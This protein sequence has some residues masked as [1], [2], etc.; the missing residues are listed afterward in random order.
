MTTQ[1]NEQPNLPNKRELIKSY[2]L[3][4]KQRRSFAEKAADVLTENFGT[5]TFLVINVVLF[6]LWILANTGHIPSVEVFDPYPFNFLTMVVSL[7]A[8]ILSIIV[9]MSQ[10]REAK[11]SDVRSEVDTHVDIVAE[12]EIT[13][14]LELMVRLLK[15]NGI[16]VS[17]DEA[18]AKML[19]PVDKYY[20]EKKFE[21]EM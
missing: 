8:I 19:K 18:L 10:N 20:L 6:F 14:L 12:E 17:E 5:F 15:K 2:K 1:E 7:E 9:L 3:K 16:D 4:S 21:K 11:T 13:K